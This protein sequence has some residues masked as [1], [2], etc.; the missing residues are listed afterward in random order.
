MSVLDRLL[1][2]NTRFAMNHRGTFNHLPMALTALARLGASDARLRQYFDW[3]EVNRAL[4]RAGE[5][6]AVGRGNWRDGLGRRAA[7][8]PLADD[9]K[10]A[11]AAEG[12]DAIAVEIGPAVVDAPGSLAFHAAIRLAYGLEAGHDGE[13]AAGLACWVAGRADLGLAALVAARPSAASV[14]EGLDAIAAAVGGRPPM[15]GSITGAMA[16]VAADPAFRDALTG[17][18][19]KGAELLPLLE[20]AAVRLYW[21]V[22][23]FTLLHLATGAHAA[24]V[25]AE[26]WPALAQGVFAD[27]L[28]AD[29][30]AAYATVGAPRFEDRAPDGPAAGWPQI[31]AAAAASDDDHVIKLTWTCFDETRRRGGD[32]WRIVATRL[33]LPPYEAP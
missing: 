29:W 8:A 23:N 4:P 13:I 3:W 22:P 30:C 14:R 6:A 33:T 5:E 11:I 27:A 1:D 26:R 15:S 16:K 10:R 19:A 32:E 2:E 12:A 9:L 21:Q 28:W 20:R 18:P 25:I 24:R 7:F 31:F 17:A